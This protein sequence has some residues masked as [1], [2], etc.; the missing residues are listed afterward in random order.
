M[1]CLH[2]TQTGVSVHLSLL[3]TLQSEVGLYVS[4]RSVM[5][6]MYDVC[7]LTPSPV[8]MLLVFREE[9]SSC[10]DL[11]SIQLMTLF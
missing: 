7:S 8:S 6:I 11:D 9:D 1:A 10:R 3:F 5:S 2:V 4:G